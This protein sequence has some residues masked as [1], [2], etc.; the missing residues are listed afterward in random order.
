[1]VSKFRPNTVGELVKE[2]CHYVGHAMGLTHCK[3]KCLMHV[4]RSER[5]L[6]RKP[7]HLSFSCQEKV[8][9]LFQIVYR[10]EILGGKVVI[11]LK[12]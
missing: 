3:Q 10:L 11:N 5:H 2:V 6:E 4:S 12:F 1:M 9:K 8:D 7:L